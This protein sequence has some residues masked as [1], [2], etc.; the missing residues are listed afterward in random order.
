[1]QVQSHNPFA[2]SGA[3]KPAQPSGFFGA[4]ETKSAARTEFDAFAKK[5]PA[6]Q[7]REQILK[8]LGLDED[9]VKAMDPKEREA[10]EAK[11]K[12]IIKTKIEEAQKEKGEVAPGQ[13]V[14]IKA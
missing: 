7:M 5:T 13:V 4:T 9:K 2:I 1:M 8:S 14:D 10:L 6:E 12:Q 3:Q 11:I